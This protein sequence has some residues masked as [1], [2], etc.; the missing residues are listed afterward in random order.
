ML[1]IFWFEPCPTSVSILGSFIQALKEKLEEA[2]NEARA[3]AAQQKADAERTKR[4]F[5]QVQKH[6]KGICSL[7]LEIMKMH[8]HHDKEDVVTGLLSY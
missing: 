5:S 1:C 4:S 3:F 6:V 2:V 8:G 7:A